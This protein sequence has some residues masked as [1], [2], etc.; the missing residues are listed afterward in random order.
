MIR[1]KMKDMKPNYIYDVY[2]YG[3]FG[4]PDSQSIYLCRQGLTDGYVY[5]KELKQKIQQYMNSGKKMGLNVP[6][7]WLVREFKTKDY[8]IIELGHKDEFPE[9][10]L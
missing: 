9:Y 6:W 2:F 5:H 1:I 3:Q 4:R 7:K 8:V 10:M